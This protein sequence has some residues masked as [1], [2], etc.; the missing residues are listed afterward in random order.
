LV[1]GANDLQ[2]ETEQIENWI[3]GCIK[4]DRRAQEALYKAYYRAM[5]S[6]CLRYT[7]SSADAVDA[8]N[9]GFFKV[10]KNIQQYD[11]KKGSL[12]TWI[13]ILVI[14]SCLDLIKQKEKIKSAQELEEGMEVAI[15]AGVLEKIEADEL[16]SMIRR[17]PP[18]TGAVFNLFA[19][20]GFSHKEIA[21]MMHISE[22]TSKWHLSEAR[23]KLQSMIQPQNIHEREI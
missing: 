21:A 9:N 5:V 6:L 1:C 22:G 15:P 19:I 2:Q 7:G 20:E 10:F 18:A 13:R 4:N 8:L 3:D 16:L 17:L 12:Y 23:R 14:N 11:R